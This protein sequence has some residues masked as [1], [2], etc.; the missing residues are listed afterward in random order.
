MHDT[1]VV[2]NEFGE[3]GVDHLL[4]ASV[5]DDV[6]LLTSGCVCCNAGDD[7]G[8]TLASML[9]RRNGGALPPFQRIVL[10]TT[11]IADPSSVLRRLLSDADLAA[12]IRI[13]AVVTV[14]D[15]VFGEAAL[16]RHTECASQVAVANR[17]VI[18]KLDLVHRGNVDTLLECLCSI[19]PA[20]PILLSGRDGPYP[21]ITYS[22]T[23]MPMPVLPLAR[24][25][26]WRI[27]PFA[28]AP[29]LTMRIVTPPFGSAGMNLLIGK[30]SKHGSKDC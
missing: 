24:F 4:I 27:G 14:V 19:N 20:A 30:I 15:A 26:R 1:A 8:A 11:G 25:R 28:E 10:E 6:V 21:P 3:V 2:V 17:L 16:S 18:S 9:T 13:Q 29:A 22:A 5:I 7:L 12:Q 23:R